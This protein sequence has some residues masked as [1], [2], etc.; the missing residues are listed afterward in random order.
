MDKVNA[1]QEIEAN[2]F[3]LSLLMPT[4]LLSKDAERYRN[5]NGGFDVERMVP[6]L[7]LKYKVTHRM[8]EYRLTQLGLLSLVLP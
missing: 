8:M 6:S 3:A 7:A 2:E 1:D 5:Y 4:K